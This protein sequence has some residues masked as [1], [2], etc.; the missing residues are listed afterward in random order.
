MPV[1]LVLH[2]YEAQVHTHIITMRAE[3]EINATAPARRSK[4]TQPPQVNAVQADA[5]R[6]C[7]ASIQ[8]ML[9]HFASCLEQAAP[10]TLNAL[11]SF[12]FSRAAYC[13]VSLIVLHFS[14]SVPNSR[15][16]SAIPDATSRLT[17][18]GHLNRLLGALR[19]S[20]SDETRRPMQKFQLLLK[21]LRAW[22]DRARQ[23]ASAGA[24]KP[25]ARARSKASPAVSRGASV[26][27]SSATELQ[28]QPAEDGR[29]TPRMGYRKLSVQLPGSDFM[30][31]ATA[32]EDSLSTD[33][34]VSMPMQGYVS[35]PLA[36]PRPQGGLHHTSSWPLAYPHH[37][38]APASAIARRHSPGWFDAGPGMA[39]YTMSDP[40]VTGAAETFANPVDENGTSADSYVGFDPGPWGNASMSL[41]PALEQAMGLA[42]GAEGHLFG[43]LV[44]D[45]FGG[46]P[47]HSLA[48]A[49]DGQGAG[50]ADA[51]EGW[52]G[53]A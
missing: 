47:T 24:S 48:H 3:E 7:V 23:S 53:A 49:R 16:A 36:S 37:A 44:D 43:S 46:A 34:H 21:M 38:S 29:T 40:H 33:H 19:K 26:P 31:T 20:A 11:P 15:I 14:A 4:Q 50:A 8:Q 42:L 10:L 1:S 30:D 6:S 39:Q 18:A 28:P 51:F 9:G 27:P 32:S 35:A 45:F 17:V 25:S 2:L 22:F 52:F 12:H 5:I 13:L 41:D